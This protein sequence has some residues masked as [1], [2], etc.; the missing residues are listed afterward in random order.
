[1][2]KLNSAWLKQNDW[3]RYSITKDCVYCVHCT[4]FG[5]S[6]PKLKTFTLKAPVTDWANLGQFVKR[7]LSPE[8]Q[9]HGYVQM[10]LNFIDIESTKK[11]SIVSSISSS[12]K[13]D[14]EKNRHILRK[15]IDVIVMCGRQN[16]PLRGHVEDKSNLMSILHMFAKDDPIL[17]DHLANA[18]IKYTSP[19]IQNEIIEICGKQIEDSLLQKCSGNYFALLAD[20]TTDKATQTQLCVCLRFVDVNDRGESSIHECF[21][22][23]LHAKSLKGSDICDLLVEFMRTKNIAIDLMRAQGYD[24]ASNMSGRVN[25]VQALMKQYA[26]NAVYVHCKAHCLNLAVVH[27]CKEQCVRT[28]MATVQEIGFAFGYSAKRMT[29]F[30]EELENNLNAKEAMDKKTKVTQLCETRWISRADALSTFK[31]AF[32][33]VVQA[34]E[35]LQTLNDDKAGMYLNSI[36]RFEFVIGLVVCEHIMRIVVHL[37]YF[38]Q[39]K[40]CDMMAAMEECRVV[41][42]QLR[43][44]RA[45]DAV[46][47]SLYEEA[48]VIG[49]DYGVVPSI[50]RRAGRQQHR[51]N[52]PA[53]EPS[54]YWRRS[55]FYV[56]IDHMAQELE[57]RLL[58]GEPHYTAFKLMPRNVIRGITDQEVSGIYDTYQADIHCE[59]A[60]FEKEVSRWKT[61]WEIAGDRPDEL[62]EVLD[63][64]AQQL[65]PSICNILIILLTIPVSTAT[66]ERSFSALRRIKTYLRSTTRQDRLSSLAMI[67]VHRDIPIDMDRVMEVFIT[68]KKRKLAFI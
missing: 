7:H 48:N 26:P 2:R 56:F 15:I 46:W 27:S 52:I 19:D 9:H 67:H 39:D 61:R 60:E 57:D 14:V 29:T 35:H 31:N 6:D 68:Q 44:E 50:P 45:D 23:F 37:S 4:I 10:G 40:S 5:H 11:D 63:R 30:M 38:L 32:P 55:L 25:G 51:A 53:D 62:T 47:T 34:L 20:E 28:M 54:D 59:Q 13:A 8:S 58:K 16:I 1:M 66:A 49:Q 21:V 18:K 22:G 24:G 36:L 65:Y 33:V 12:H 17:A 41:I 43:A 42:T 64:T 3:M